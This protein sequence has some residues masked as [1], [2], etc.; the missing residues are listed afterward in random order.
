VPD[1]GAISVKDHGAVGD[2]RRDDTGAL[3][4]AL[5]AAL[6][7]EKSLYLPAGVYAVSLPLD[8]RH[9]GLHVF[10]DGRNRSIVRQTGT[11]RPIILCGEQHQHI[12]DLSFQYAFQA[13]PDDV[14][15]V[16]IELFKPCFSVYERLTV[17]WAHKG[18]GIHQGDYDSATDAEGGNYAF[19]N[20]WRDIEVLGFRA[21]G[22]DLTAYNRVSTGSV[23]GNVYVS[24]APLGLAEESS[25][26]PVIIKDSDGQIFNQLNIESVVCANSDVL[27]VQGS[28]VVINGLHMEEVTLSSW[29]GALVQ[30]F[31][32]GNTQINM[33]TVQASTVA[34]GANNKSVVKVGL[35]ARVRLHGLAMRNRNTIESPVFA[36]MQS[37]DQSGSFI[38]TEVDL[39]PFTTPTLGD[40]GTPRVAVQIN[41]MGMLNPLPPD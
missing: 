4:A 15:S 5:G 29:D 1:S 35:N 23:W 17:F 37:L 32:A 11:N 2:G 7:A 18:I 8:W 27:F 22:I 36:L 24:N 31:D 6:E 41:E 40:T 39:S 30:A 28:N 14:G 3:V 20:S 38:A 9:E 21:S 25:T 16:G 13:G 26:Y 33:M 19:S 34:G 10:G 12:N